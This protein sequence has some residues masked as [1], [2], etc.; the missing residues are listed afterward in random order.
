MAKKLT[1]AEKVE[2]AK[3]REEAKVEEIM[4]KLSGYGYDENDAYLINEPTAKR[5]KDRKWSMDL[6]CSCCQDGTSEYGAF[7]ATT[8]LKMLQKALRA[9]KDNGELEGHS[10]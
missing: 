9:V 3:E 10:K 8:K 6:T 5:I 1:K 2:L 4:E 7:A